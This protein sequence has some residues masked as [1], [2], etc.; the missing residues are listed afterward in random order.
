VVSLTYTNP[1]YT[2]AHLKKKWWRDARGG[3]YLH[4][5]E[6]DA[7]A[8][9][10]AAERVGLHGS[11]GVR[12]HVVVVTPALLAAVRAQLAPAADS[13][14]LAHCGWWRRLR[15]A[16]GIKREGWGEGDG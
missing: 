16:G 9:G 10:G 3:V 1:L 14:R 4:L 5:L 7:L 12:L 11:H 15:A 6:H 13:L 8:H 2:W